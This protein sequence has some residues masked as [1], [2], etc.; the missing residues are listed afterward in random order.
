VRLYFSH[1][2]DTAL[3]ETPKCS[4]ILV[5]GISQTILANSSLGGI[6]LALSL[7]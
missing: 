4:A 1:H 7:L 6:F 2:L 3:S 5:V